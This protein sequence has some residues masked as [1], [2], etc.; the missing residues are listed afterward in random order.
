MF[1]QGLGAIGTWAPDFGSGG[2]YATPIEYTP[3]L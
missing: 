2:S 3:G 1:T